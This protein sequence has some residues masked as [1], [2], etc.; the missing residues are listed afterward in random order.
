MQPTPPSR[1]GFTLI[2]LLVVIAIIAMLAGLLLPGLSGARNRARVVVGHSNMRSMGQVV[3]AFTTDHKNELYNP[4]LHRIADPQETGEFS[5][6][7]GGNEDRFDTESMMPFWWSNMLDNEP[8]SGLS[9]EVAISPA[10]GETLTSERRNL[11]TDGLNAGSFYYSPTMWRSPDFFSG[12]SGCCRNPYGSLYRSDCCNDDCSRC[13]ECCNLARVLID[14]ASS[15]SAKV[16]LFERA[17]FFQKKRVVIAS[18]SRSEPLSP[19]FNNPRAKPGVLTLDGSVT[20][21][22]VSLL[23]ELAQ[24]GIEDPNYRDLLPSDLMN[25]PTRISGSSAGAP[26]DGLDIQY[27]DGLYPAF[28]QTTR[29]GIRGRD[30]NR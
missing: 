15:P 30:L 2:E 11:S 22:D 6:S 26:I 17:D 14:Q 3:Q 25:V 4:F 20:Q 28:F 29:N 23:T 13:S 19:A 8:N 1:R 5:L 18:E 21:V 9:R 27:T 7:F 10:D 12:G 24:K 16:M